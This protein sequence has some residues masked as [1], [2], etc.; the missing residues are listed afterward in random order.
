M[1]LNCTIVIYNVVAK[2]HIWN[3][4]TYP[5]KL[6][7]LIYLFCA[8]F[9][10][11]L[12]P[13]DLLSAEAKLL[14][15]SQENFRFELLNGKISST[16]FDFIQTKF[17]IFLWLYCHFSTSSKNI[18]HWFFKHPKNCRFDCTIAIYNVATKWY[19]CF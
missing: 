3:Y 4:L 15:E 12:F 13:W 6:S 1:R 17:L 19:I 11:M 14:K 9:P 2:W 10:C 7:N 16:A 8:H 18:Q 5:L